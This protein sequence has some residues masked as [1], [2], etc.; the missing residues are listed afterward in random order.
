MYMK[1][2]VIFTLK[3]IPVYLSVS[4]S[5]SIPKISNQKFIKTNLF[6]MFK[7]EIK[8]INRTMT[9]SYDQIRVC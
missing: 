2:N 3:H 7:C 1:L 5:E 6:P 9:I 8:A 4:N